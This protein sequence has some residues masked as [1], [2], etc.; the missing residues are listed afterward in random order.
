[1][2]FACARIRTSFICTSMCE[3]FRVQ[4]SPGVRF[5]EP[6]GLFKTSFLD[7]PDARTLTDSIKFGAWIP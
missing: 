1:M 5:S 7:V 3:Q 4:T 6:Q 2:P